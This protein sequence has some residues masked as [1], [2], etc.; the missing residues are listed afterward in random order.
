MRVF[1]GYMR[2]RL[3]GKGI[4]ELLVGVENWQFFLERALSSHLFL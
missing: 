4:G 1:A 3:G 2:R